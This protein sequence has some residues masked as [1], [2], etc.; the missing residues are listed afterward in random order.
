[1]RPTFPGAF[2]RWN[3]VDAIA[4]SRPKRGND[5]FR[6]CSGKARR[7]A[8]SAECLD[9]LVAVQIFSL[10]VAYRSRV[11]TKH[12]IER[13]NIV[14]HQRSFVPFEGCSDLRNNVGRSICMLP[15]PGWNSQALSAK[16]EI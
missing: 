1:M 11:L 7:R 16:R 4:K 6:Q 12:L 3:S 2:V 15:L 9:F 8:H 14:A 10:A 5:G 13:H